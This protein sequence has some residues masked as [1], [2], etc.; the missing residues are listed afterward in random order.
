MGDA[1]G[2]SNMFDTSLN[3]RARRPMRP[4]KVQ[5][6]RLASLDALSVYTIWEI[7][8]CSHG[9]MRSQHLTI[10]SLKER[11]KFSVLGN[12]FDLGQAVFVNVHFG[13]SQPHFG[14][15]FVLKHSATALRQARRVSVV[16]V[17]VHK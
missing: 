15:N 10:E 14:R 5:V 7:V 8:I 11:S 9:Q 13:R 17:F 12:A 2:C 16:L 3:Q 4:S 6:Q 1:N